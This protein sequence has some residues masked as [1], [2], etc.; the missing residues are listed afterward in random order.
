MRRV[1]SLCS[2]WL[3]Y[4]ILCLS[5]AKS[6]PVDFFLLLSYSE[7]CRIMRFCSSFSSRNE[8]ISLAW[9]MFSPF[10]VIFSMSR[11]EKGSALGLEK[12]YFL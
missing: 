8:S 9:P 5:A 11:K 2:F 12:A 10:A 4:S 7:I 6:P 1:F 3:M